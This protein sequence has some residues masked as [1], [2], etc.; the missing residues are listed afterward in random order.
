VSESISG[1]VEGIVVRFDGVV[2]VAFEPGFRTNV[3]S[4]RSFFPEAETFLRKKLLP[5]KSFKF[6]FEQAVTLV[7]PDHSRDI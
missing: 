1:R 3:R 6:S 2:T 5:M 4:G 7:L